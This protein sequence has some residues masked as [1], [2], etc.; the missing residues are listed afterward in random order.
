MQLMIN[1]P[2]SGLDVLT[3]FNF[4]HHLILTHLARKSRKYRAFFKKQKHAYLIL[5]NSVFETGSPTIDIA[6][7]TELGVQ[8]VVGPDYMF[9]GRKTFVETTEFA[10]QHRDRFRIMGVVQGH[11]RAEFL[12]CLAR[13]Y[14]SPHIDVIGL[15]KKACLAMLPA[16]SKGSEKE[17]VWARFDAVSFMLQEEMVSKEVHLLGLADPQELLLYRDVGF[18]RSIDTSYPFR[19]LGYSVDH[20]GR[21]SFPKL[22]AVVDEIRGLLTLCGAPK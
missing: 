9:D 19:V 21:I 3:V 12:E 2:V 1:T 22:V 10:K 13:F 20:E 5:D 18:I 7:A 8:E 14:E 6:L 16:S 15:G 4:S 11:D 17:M